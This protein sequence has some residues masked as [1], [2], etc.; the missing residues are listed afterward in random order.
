MSGSIKDLIKQEKERRKL[1]REERKK[2]E[3][4]KEQT[5]GESYL[6]GKDTPE[7]YYTKSAQED[8]LFLKIQ[9]N[10]EHGSVT[11]KYNNVGEELCEVD[12][13]RRPSGGM[14]FNEQMTMKRNSD[15]KIDKRVR[16]MEPTAPINRLNKN[17]NF[18]DAFL[19]YSNEEQSDNS[20]GASK[21]KEDE[22]HVEDDLPADFFDSI[23]TSKHSSSKQNDKRSTTPMEGTPGGKR[24]PN[25]SILF[26]DDEGVS[27]APL[28]YGL[29]EEKNT[30]GGR[31]TSSEE[32]SEENPDIEQQSGNK[33]DLKKEPNVEVIETYEITEDTLGSAE[34]LENENFHRQIKKKRKLL[35][36]GEY[37]LDEEEK[38]EKGPFQG[39]EKTHR[40][41]M[42][43]GKGDQT[44]GEGEQEGNPIMDLLTTN[45][46]DLTNYKLLDTA[47]YEELDYL[48]KMLVEK[49]KYI[50]GDTYDEEKEENEEREVELLEELNQFRK[51][52]KKMEKGRDDEGNNDN[53][54]HFNIDEIYDML[55]LKRGMREA[56]GHIAHTSGNTA[57]SRYADEERDDGKKTSEYGN[58]PRGFFDD[59]EKDIMVRENISLPK[60]NQKIGEIKKQKKNILLEFKM[61]ENAY[62]EKKNSYI[63]YL[64]DDKFDDKEHI[65]DEIVRKSTNRGVVEMN[66]QED[67]QSEK[68]KKK[69]KKEKKKV[70]RNTNH[71]QLDDEHGDIFHWRNKSLF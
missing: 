64:Y 22:K 48:H 13:G 41:N 46:E 23:V 31:S 38:D 9:N 19:D 20:E 45:M 34:L 6:I 55:K 61:M 39:G 52:K 12:Q 17:N 42:S 37:H 32:V 68:K 62:Q 16:F 66:T 47:Y 44:D 63:D 65:L 18:K 67:K 49:K 59:K 26:P 5:A 60:I 29:S 70:K 2:A 69:K 50:L 56:D 10:S 14:V 1:L 40:R 8:R 57:T 36:E 35:L 21:D 28:N 15:N 53:D 25:K 4:E 51:K 24:K 33:F 30:S 7:N 27:G 54:N 3:K 58:L 11:K 71:F 43:I